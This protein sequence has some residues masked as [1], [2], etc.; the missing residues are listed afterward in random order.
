MEITS[1]AYKIVGTIELSAKEY[2]HYMNSPTT[3]D[4]GRIG[5]IIARVLHKTKSSMTSKRIWNLA[6][7]TL[8][9]M[10]ALAQEPNPPKWDETSVKVFSP[11]NDAATQQTVNDVFAING[12][13]EPADHG[14][15]SPYRSE[16]DS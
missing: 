8:C 5:C 3:Q 9:A 1:D 2:K 10:G 15:F 4:I 11:G 7:A 13:H 16:C 12:G 14:Q 6:C